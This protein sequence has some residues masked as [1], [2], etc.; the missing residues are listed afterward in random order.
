MLAAAALPNELFYFFNWSYYCSQ[1]NVAVQELDV[2]LVN[3]NDCNSTQNTIQGAAKV[4]DLSDLMLVTSLNKFCNDTSSVLVDQ[5]LAGRR[6]LSDSKNGKRR[7][8]LQAGQRRLPPAL[9]RKGFH[10][11][12]SRNKCKKRDKWLHFR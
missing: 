11:V 7:K 10:A 1:Y 2:G 3:I 5:D 9:E 8:L 12:Y 6:L 4:I